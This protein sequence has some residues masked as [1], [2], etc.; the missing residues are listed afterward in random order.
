M[1]YKCDVCLE[2]LG[3]SVKYVPG[4]G[5]SCTLCLIATSTIWRDAAKKVTRKQIQTN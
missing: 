5:E 4:F 2:V 3:A 1:K